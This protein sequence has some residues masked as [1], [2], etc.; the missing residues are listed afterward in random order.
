M[1]QK[2]AM[3]SSSSSSTS[4]DL[5]PSTSSSGSSPYH[6]LRNMD[7]RQGNDTIVS[8]NEGGETSQKI[9]EERDDPFFIPAK[10]ASIEMLRK[11]RV[12]CLWICY[13]SLFFLIDYVCGCVWMWWD[14]L[15]VGFWERG[16]AMLFL[17][18]CRFT[19]CD[20]CVAD[21]SLL[22]RVV[23]DCSFVAF[24]QYFWYDCSNF[25]HRVATILMRKQ[26][27]EAQTMFQMRRIFQCCGIWWD[28]DTSECSEL[29]INAA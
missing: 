5:A 24:L 28:A 1:Q 23:V 15:S 17:S 3:R 6:R 4:I 9:P 20:L 2:T 26:F 8:I 12:N 18:Q 13:L 11:W 19:S 10:N 7:S 22:H 25:Q 29:C 16:I 21:C 27:N 14:C